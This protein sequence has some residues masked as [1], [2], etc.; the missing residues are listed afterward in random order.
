MI[1]AQKVRRPSFE[2]SLQRQDRFH[3]QL[4]WEISSTLFQTIVIRGVTKLHYQNNMS[5]V[6][7]AKRIYL[8]RDEITIFIIMSIRNRTICGSLCF[9]M[10]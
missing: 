10:H 8:T 4:L 3:I 5:F 7:V 6:G 2:T 1:G 9:G